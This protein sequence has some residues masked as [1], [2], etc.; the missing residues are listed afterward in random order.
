GGGAPRAPEGLSRLKTPPHLWGGGAEGAGGA[1]PFKTPP[2]LWGGGAEGAG[3]AEPFKTPPHLWGGVRRSRT[4]GPE[5]LSRGIRPEQLDLRARLL[6]VAQRRLRRGGRRRLA[7][8][9]EVDVEP[10]LERPPHHRPAVQPREVDPAPREAVQRVRQAARPMRG[11]E[12]D[13]PLPPRTAVARARR[14]ALLDH[15][16]AGAIL[17]VVL[18]RLRQH[19]QPVPRSRRLRGNRRRPRPP[20]PSDRAR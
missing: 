4:E 15:H 17:R 5:Q 13:R 9:R 8:D 14:R 19:V 1:Q 16:E 10:V 3:G 7:V 11:D 20:L 12:R 2:H 18:D 6:Q